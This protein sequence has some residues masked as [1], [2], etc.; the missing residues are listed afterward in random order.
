MLINSLVGRGANEASVREMYNSVFEYEIKQFIVPAYYKINLDKNLHKKTYQLTKQYLD[1]IQPKHQLT[2]DRLFR[3]NVALKILF[4]GIWMNQSQL[5]SSD[6]IT[7]DDPKI[8][9]LWERFKT[10]NVEKVIKTFNP[11][12]DLFAVFI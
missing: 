12:Y 7:T 3:M 1:K 4:P 2:E 6:K 10:F 9:V 5:I 8:K 11:V